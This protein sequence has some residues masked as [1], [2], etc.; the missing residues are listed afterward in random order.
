M[1]ALNLEDL[2]VTRFEAWIDYSVIF[3]FLAN[4][5]THSLND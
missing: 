3:L 5:A 2:K 4:T 1:S